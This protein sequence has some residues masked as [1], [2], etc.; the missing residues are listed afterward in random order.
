MPNYL[1]TESEHATTNHY[2]ILFTTKSS[3]QNVAPESQFLELVM[4]GL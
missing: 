4:L 1:P 3:G 2:K